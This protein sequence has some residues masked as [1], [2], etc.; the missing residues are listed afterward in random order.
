MK[1]TIAKWKFFRLGLLATLLM[2]IVLVSCDKDDPAPSTPTDKTALS[3]AIATA[4]GLLANTVEGTHPGQYEVGSQAALA[5]A[6]AAANSVYNNPDATQAAINNATQQLLAAI[7]AY[8]GHLI[9]EI[10]ASSLVGFW[11]MNGNTNDSSGNNRHGV[12]TTGHP[13]FG[14]G[15]LSSTADRFGRANMAYSF[16][17]GAN[18]QVPYSAALNPQAMS[19]SLW[20]KWTSTGRTLNPDTYTFVALNRWNGYKFQLQ[21]GHL[22]FYTVKVLRGPGDTT[23]YDR[24]DA[25]VPIIENEWH[26]IVVTFQS[27]TMSFYIDGDHVKTWDASTPNP[28]PGTALTLP[29]PIDFVI[30]QDLPTDKYLTVDG[31]F[32]VAWGGFFTGD[33]DDVMLYNIALSGPQVHSIFVN[34]NTL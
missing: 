2:G 30:G 26:H 32:Q 14:A 25:G 1:S 20:A 17:K 4:N 6:L 28:V 15:T 3:S 21:G 11:K 23:I 22:P 8:Q 31:D 34:Q 16:D 19:I 13:F 5:A 9:E 33:M 27:G 7:A 29:T 24:D 18:I 10:A 12:A